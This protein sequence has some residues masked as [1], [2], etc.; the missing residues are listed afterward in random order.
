MFNRFKFFS[1]LSLSVSSTV[2]SA[3]LTLSSQDIAHGEFMPKTHE[4]KGYI[5]ITLQDADGIT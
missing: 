3:P 4:F 5:P 1:V 2:F